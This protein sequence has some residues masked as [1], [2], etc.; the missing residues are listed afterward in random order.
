M[1]DKAVVKAH[2]SFWLIGTFALLWN[3]GGSINF[4]MQ[5]NPEM[6][7]MYRDSERAIIEGR[8][9]WATAGFAIGVFGGAI[10]CLFLLLKNSAAFY[11]F[12]GSLLG[13]ILTMI[14]TISVASTEY[15]FSPAEI[16]LM[17]VSPVVVAAVLVW[18]SNLVERKG[19]VS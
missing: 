14:H 19:W 3:I 4:I 11:I 10:G 16:F 12:I 15:S 6:I 8:P 13:I 7:A 9:V 2:W 18:Y 1:D 17:A 5:M